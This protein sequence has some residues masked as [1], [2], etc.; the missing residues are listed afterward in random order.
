MA[1]D[2]TVLGEVGSYVITAP[3]QLRIAAIAATDGSYGGVVSV[4]S[5]GNV[6]FN[7]NF[8]LRRISVGSREAFGEL[9]GAASVRPRLDGTDPLALDPARGSF[10]QLNG[11]AS[12]SVPRAQLLFSVALRRQRNER[13]SYTVGPAFR[14]EVLRAGS[15]RATFNG[16]LAFTTAGRSGF[17]G[18]SLQVLGAGSTISSGI[19]LRSSKTG[20]DHDTSSIRTITGAWQVDEVAGGPL[21]VGA[22]YEDDAGRKLLSASADL[23]GD[24]LALSGDVSRNFGDGNTQYSLGFQTMLAAGNGGISLNGGG[25]MDSSA[26]VEVRGARKSDRFE[27]LV[28]DTVAG[29]VAVG[30]PLSLPLASYRQYKVRLRPAGAAPLRYDDTERTVALYPGNVPR[31]VWTAEPVVTMFGRIVVSDGTPILGANIAGAKSIGQ[32]DEHGYFQIDAAPGSALQ[33][34]GP[35]G[36]ACRVVLQTVPDGPGFASVGTLI[37][38]RGTEPTFAGATMANPNPENRP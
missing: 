31:L 8:D 22:G 21:G 27:V 28:D 19:G 15:L 37:C 11:V 20:D 32:T 34:E 38:R 16:D 1:T 3:A 18:L 35:D 24:R 23:R 36:L 25:A 2:R 30:K 9:T 12:Y 7:Y 14:W 6:H 5:Q 4:S 10:T 13:A 29:F 26:V 17:L 33:L